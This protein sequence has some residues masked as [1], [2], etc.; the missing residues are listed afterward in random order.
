MK[1]QLYATFGIQK[2]QVLFVNFHANYSK[3][4]WKS[5]KVLIFVFQHE[6]NIAEKVTFTWA[7]NLIWNQ[8]IALEKKS[9][10]TIEIN[11]L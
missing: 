8:F 11:Y 3:L 2:L 5:W 4:F 10:K 1:N 9:L 7:L 6:E